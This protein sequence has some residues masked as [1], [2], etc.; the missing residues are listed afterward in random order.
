M[1]LSIGKEVA[2]L[3][4]MTVKELRDKYAELFDD[5]TRTGNKRE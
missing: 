5:E 1:S 2:A 3:K 4:K